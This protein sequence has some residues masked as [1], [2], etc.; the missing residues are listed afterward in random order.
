MATANNNPLVKHFRQPTIY[1]KLP[2]G[3][4]FY[5]PNSLE[6]TVSGEIPIY[7]MTVKDELSLKTPDALMNG[8]AMVQ[9]LRSCC[10]SI[11]DPWAIPSID[12]DAI[13]IALR[14]ASYG[15]GMDINSKC[16][17]CSSQNEH[18]INLINLLESIPQANVDT[19]VEIDNMVFKYKP[20]TYKDINLINIKTFE[21]R[22][23][24]NNIIASDLPDEQKKE[25]FNE[26]FKKLTDMNLQQVLGNIESITVDGQLVTSAEHIKEY[27]NNASRQVYVKIKSEAEKALQANKLP[28]VELTCNE[29]TKE[30]KTDIEFDQANFF[31]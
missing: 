8:D 26:S 31:E 14:I 21:E 11:T 1:L 15:T 29:C 7:P 25:A 22:R 6:L 30:Y 12:I 16:P 3:G 18:T 28:P 23:L 19:T 24:I 10:P 17:H 2:S 5:P 4:R 27:L 20:P 9:V 13:F